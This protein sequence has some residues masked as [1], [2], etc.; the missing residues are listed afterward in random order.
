MLNQYEAEV[1]GR[2]ELAELK[3]V[4]KQ[5]VAAEVLPEQTEWERDG[6]IP[7]ALHRAAGDLGLIGAGFPEAVGGGGGGLLATVAITEAGDEAGMSGG[8][9]A[10]LFTAGIA[11]PHMVLAGSAEQ[12]DRFVRPTLAGELIGS[13][14]ITE[15]SGGS[16]V[17]HLR[18][19]AERED[20]HYVISGSKTFIT[21]ATR[22]DFVTTAV[23]TGGPG[24]RGVSL[25]VVPTDTPGFGVAKKLEKM[26]WRASDTA[27]LFYDRV[28]VPASMLIGEEGA[29]F[30][31]IS[32]GFVSE[33]VSLAVQAYASA[34]RAL[35]LT[36]Q[37]CRDRETFGKPLIARDTVQAKLAEMARR[38]D[39]ARVYTRRVA[40]RWDEFT[41]AGAAAAPEG[42]AE[43]L[44]IVSAAAFAK[45]TATINGE[46]VNREAVQLF[47]G[48]GFMAESEVER[49][50]RDS[51]VLA[52]G[53]GTV[54]IL[55]TL[56]GKHL[57]YQP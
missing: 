11:V 44:N 5:F 51:P 16:D 3:Q 38:V 18:A 37:W 15:P 8:V 41:A 19:R 4:T 57:G 29:G 24:A 31:Y 33:R 26:G 53:G 17:G 56:A 48:M 20:D 9:Y 36:V 42:D 27:E 1:I 34:Q 13:L 30:A 10:S 50:Y 12:I 6:A 32:H 40:E 35:D 39:V 22:A 47:G 7:R 14:A 23:R 2:D 46:W 52:I 54:E 45:N 25:V 49:I 55:T 43:G 28:R 21:S